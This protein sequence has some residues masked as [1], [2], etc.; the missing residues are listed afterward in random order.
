MYVRWYVLFLP[1]LSNITPRSVDTVMTRS[2]MCRSSVVHVHA[3]SYF[4]VT[5]LWRR[6]LPLLTG[7]V[8]H[9][10][11]GRG[12]GA[13]QVDSHRQEAEARRYAVQDIQE[14]CIYT[15]QSTVTI[16]CLRFVHIGRLYY[17][18][19][20]K[21]LACVLQCSCKRRTRTSLPRSSFCNKQRY[22]LL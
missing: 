22:V 17:M 10:V 16:G 19:L 13:R 11:D 20:S 5:S 15:G 12:D 18:C 1:L 4:A 8:P 21:L 6:Y 3:H 7:R 9:H 2:D 14:N